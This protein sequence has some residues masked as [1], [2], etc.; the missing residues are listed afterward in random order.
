[1]KIF[2]FTTKICGRYDYDG[3]IFRPG[4]EMM[5]SCTAIG[6]PLSITVISAQPEPWL[7]TLEAPRDLSRRP[8]GV[9]PTGTTASHQS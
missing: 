3:P 5:A 6:T 1:M 4:P 2:N 7:A 8:L 9:T